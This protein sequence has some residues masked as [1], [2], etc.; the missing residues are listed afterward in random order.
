MV[1]SSYTNDFFADLR[2]K[3]KQSAKEIVPL[4]IEMINPKSVIDVGCGEGIWLAAF[5]KNGVKDILGIDGDY[6][7]RNMLAIPV[8]RFMPVDLKHPVELKR[9]F[10][11]VVCLEVAE[12][13]PEETAAS[14]VDFLT[15]LGPVVLFS[16]AIPYQGGN[17]HV[18]EQWPD[19]WA[20]LFERKSYLTIDC[21][22]KKVWNND[23]VAWWYAQNMLLL[24]EETCLNDHPLLQRE[25]EHTNHS[26]LSAVHPHQ[27]IHVVWMKML[28]QTIQEF[29]CLIPH[30]TSF[31]V[32][33]DGKF[34]IQYWSDEAVYFPEKDGTYWGPPQD[35]DTAIRELERLLEQKFGFLV[36]LW[37]AFWWLDYYKKFN[38][39]IVSR[40]RCVLRNDRI[41]VFDL[42]SKP[43]TSVG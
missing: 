8:D 15:T 6:I 13:L 30:K 29:Y 21:I 36:I 25:L 33:D 20:A 11:L 22:R 2:K 26:S 7:D 3:T 10:D 23:N 43:D 17:Q 1:H 12:H 32:I 27:Y 37:P 5:E 24:A 14:F 19:Y 35:D 28:Y 31:I 4:V 42:Q 16:A 41:C 18:N 40:F 34:G 39:Y 38:R 9:Q